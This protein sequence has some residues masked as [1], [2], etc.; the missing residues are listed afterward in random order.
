MEHSHQGDQG[1]CNKKVGYK[2]DYN[3]S[4]VTAL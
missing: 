4:T 3:I 2:E 1:Y